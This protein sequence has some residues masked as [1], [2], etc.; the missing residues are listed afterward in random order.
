MRTKNKEIQRKRIMGYFID[1]TQQIIESEGIEN[2]TIRKISSLAGYNSATLY[3]YF[4]DLNQLIAF[5]LINSVLEYFV[6][7]NTKI[8]TT[9]E[10][11][12]TFLLTWKEYAAFSFRKPEIYTY[13]FYS[14]HSKEVLGQINNYL[15]LFPDSAFLSES[16]MQQRILGTSIED[17]DNL[18][19]DPCID[20]GY[21][22]EKDKKYIFDFC[23]ALHLGM[24]QKI[25]SGDYSNSEEVTKL[26]LDYVIDFLLSH[27]KISCDKE[28]LLDYIIN[29]K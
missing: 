20:D 6:S 17:R 16:D 23:Y 18:I 4:D 9:N 10:S 12:I 29:Y 2:V 3:N 25:K 7:L 19:A 27:S 14:K 21:I 15:E 26:Y 11:Y 13:V 5:S 1:A 28:E 24:C 8:R 22:D